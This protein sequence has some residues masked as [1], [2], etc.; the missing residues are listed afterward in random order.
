LKYEYLNNNRDFP[1]FLNYSHVEKLYLVLTPPV[2]SFYCS[3]NGSHEEEEHYLVLT[4]LFSQPHTA[5][6]S[7]TFIV[8]KMDRAGLCAD[9]IPISISDVCVFMNLFAV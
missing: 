9:N 3:K 1:F 7:K 8:A 4:H 2:Q 6:A 5:I